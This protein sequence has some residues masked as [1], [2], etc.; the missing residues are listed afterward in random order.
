MLLK[1][2]LRAQLLTLIGGSLLVI[3]LIA[4]ASFSFLSDD[5]SKYQQLLKGPIE[6][7]RLIDEANVE[8]KVQVQEWKNVLL[9]GKSPEA[10]SKYWQS[11]ENQE[12][13]VQ[14]ILGRLVERSEHNPALSKQLRDL[15]EEHRRLGAS[16]PP[17][18]RAVRPTSPA[19]TIHSP[20][21]RRF[22]ASTVPPAN[23]SVVW[24]S[25]S[26]IRR[27]IVRKPSAKPQIV[28]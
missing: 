20:A 17:T 25:S 18:A 21:T 16:A 8:F 14:D 24:S 27:C 10:L 1:K 23:S 28:K 3:L 4:F 19:E 26:A 7:S 9:R 5:I 11:F 6:T 12:R 22:K 13:K 15:H 2:S